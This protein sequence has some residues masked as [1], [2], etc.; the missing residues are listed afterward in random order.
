MEQ[1][2]ISSRLKEMWQALTFEEKSELETFAAFLL[3]RRGLKQ[4]QLITD[5]I[6]TKELIHLVMAGGSFD[7][8]DDPRED[9]YSE[10]DGE[11]IEWPSKS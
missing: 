6:S 4:D 5:D 8:L 1:T 3:T 10:K 2:Q 11:E 9:V 7:W